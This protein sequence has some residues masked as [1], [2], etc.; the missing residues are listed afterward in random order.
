MR[1]VKD[2][3]TATRGHLLSAFLRAKDP[4]AKP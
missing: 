2:K 3:H 1:V 4:I